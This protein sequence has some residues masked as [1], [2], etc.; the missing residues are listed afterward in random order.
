MR[1]VSVIFDGFNFYY[2][3]RKLRERT[4]KCYY[5]HDLY[6]LSE[7]ISAERPGSVATDTLVNK[8]VYCTA[9]IKSDDHQKVWRQQNY[10]NLLQALGKVSLI[11]GE[12]V[13]REQRCHHCDA[14]PAICSNCGEK[15]KKHQEKQTDVNLALWAIIAGYKN[16][17]D[18][19]IMVTSDADLAK[20]AQQVRQQFPGK[21][22]YYAF[23]PEQINNPFLV[24]EANSCFRITEDMLVD[25][26][27][28]RRMK[29]QGTT[30]GCP[31]EWLSGDVVSN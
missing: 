11:R 19:L 22:A 15:M 7:W 4:G 20:V 30:F 9:N 28:R 21:R 16:V 24:K 2:G 27:F 18:D 8:V 1:R 6:K 26:M 31:S 13:I 3:L 10:F 29:I 12:Y 23:P 17:Y 5:W 25:C 14:E